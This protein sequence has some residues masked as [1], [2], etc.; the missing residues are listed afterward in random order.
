MLYFCGGVFF[1]TYT[2]T[3]EMTFYKTGE[4]LLYFFNPNYLR[5]SFILL[6]THTHTHTHT[7]LAIQSPPTLRLLF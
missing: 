7:H 5:G 2:Q 1:C 4:T 6:N 3:D